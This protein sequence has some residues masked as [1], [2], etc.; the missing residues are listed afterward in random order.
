MQVSTPS[1]SRP[2]RGVYEVPKAVINRMINQ[3]DEVVHDATIELF[4]RGCT[5]GLVR[6]RFSML[7]RCQTLEE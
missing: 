5:V 7:M 1:Q 4:C 6:I 2:G 3:F